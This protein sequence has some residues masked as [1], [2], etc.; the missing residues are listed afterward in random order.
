MI[1]NK[2]E[3]SILIL[4][5]AYDCAPTVAKVI[6][7]AQKYGPVLLLDDGSRDKTALEAEKTGAFILKHKV[8]QGSGPGHS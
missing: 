1:K 8:N 5:P 4:V 6:K 3:P 2:S 7:G